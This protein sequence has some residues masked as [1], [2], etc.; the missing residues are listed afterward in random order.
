MR[1]TTKLFAGFQKDRFAVR[2]LDLPEE[3]RVQGLVDLLGIPVRAIGVILINGRHVELTQ[4][5]AADDV[6]AV[7]PV[8]GGG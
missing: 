2:D 3:T 1:V 5:L 6:V 7:F 4:T 8:I